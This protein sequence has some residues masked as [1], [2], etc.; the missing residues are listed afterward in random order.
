MSQACLS[1]RLAHLSPV[2]G[3][4][5]QGKGNAMSDQELMQRIANDERRKTYRSRLIEARVFF[6]VAEALVRSNEA[7]WSSGRCLTTREC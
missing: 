2:Y 6:T 3:Q 5:T 4:T 1:E 7:P